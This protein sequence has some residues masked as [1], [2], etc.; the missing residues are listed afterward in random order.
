M[1]QNRKY[2]CT[3]CGESNLQL[4]MNK[5]QGRK[6]WTLCK[7]CHNQRT[8]LRARKNKEAFV[9]YKGGKCER[10][11]YQ[12]ALEALEFHHIDPSQKDP[13]FRTMKFWGLEKAKIELDKCLLLCANCH[14]EKHAGI[15]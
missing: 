7:S 1:S 4:M 2:L 14:R 5:G 8:I 13:E 6:S 15:W 10:C 3:N 11:S 9:L 12:K